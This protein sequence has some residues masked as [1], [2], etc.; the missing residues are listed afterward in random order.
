MYFSIITY[1][2]T[3]LSK[4]IAVSISLR[5]INVSIRSCQRALQFTTE[6]FIA[7]R[8]VLSRP[9]CSK[10]YFLRQLLQQIET[11]LNIYQLYFINMYLNIATIKIGGI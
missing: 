10:R 4:Y 7:N 8:N 2:W 3:G 5:H 1:K 11:R 9:L 6:L